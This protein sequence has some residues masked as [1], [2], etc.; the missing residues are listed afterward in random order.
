MT[1]VELVTFVLIVWGVVYTTT[2]SA[3]FA[4]VRLALLRWAKP[5]PMGLTFMYCPK[6]QAFWV[7]V[8]LSAL[9]TPVEALS[10]A[11]YVLRVVAYGFAAMGATAATHTFTAWAGD[12]YNVE[13]SSSSSSSSEAT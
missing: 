10:L 12:A 4:I 3:A 7:G 9:M 6:C 1:I 11:D 8:A 5:G 2:A 13:V